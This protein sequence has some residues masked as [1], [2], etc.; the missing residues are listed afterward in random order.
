M[1]VFARLRLETLDERALPSAGNVLSSS[2][3]DLT[4]RQGHVM[5]YDS[6]APG[7]PHGGSEDIWVVFIIKNGDANLQTGLESAKNDIGSFF[8][9]FVAEEMAHD[10]PMPQ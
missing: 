9:I 4:P 8:D 3:S 7:A 6:F 2:L 5:G 1:S 10:G